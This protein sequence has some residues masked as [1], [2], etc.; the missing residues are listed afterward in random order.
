M[1]I[2]YHPQFEKSYRKLSRLIKS[3]A[4]AREIIFRENPFDIRL[5]AHKLHGPLKRQWSFSINRK[6]RILF[7]FHGPD[8]IFLD[9]GNHELY[10]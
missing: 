6:Y 1:V 9:I 4:E 5:D 2:Y 7:E 10:R 3:K 8:V